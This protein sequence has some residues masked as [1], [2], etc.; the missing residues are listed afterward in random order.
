MC[1]SK[2]VACHFNLP[3]HS[4]HN[5]TLLSFPTPRNRRKPL[6]PRTKIS[7]LGTLIPHVAVNAFG[8]SNSFIRLNY[9]SSNDITPLLVYKLTYYSTIASFYHIWSR[10]LAKYETVIHYSVPV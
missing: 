10:E 1:A 3:N 7:Q 9:F 6:E 5:M 4:T 8:S 2:P